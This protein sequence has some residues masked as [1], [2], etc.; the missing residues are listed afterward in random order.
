[1][2]DTFWARINQESA[3]NDA[4]NLEKDIAPVEITFV[5][6]GTDGDTFLDPGL[7]P[8]T[9][10]LINGTLYDFEYIVYGTLPNAQQVPD[11]FE[12]DAVAIIRVIGYPTATETERFVFLP[13]ANATESDMAS[14]QQGN[15]SPI[16]PDVLPQVPVC[17]AAGTLIETPRGPVLVDDLR[18][19]DLVMTVDDGP[20]P[21]IWATSSHHVWPGSDEKFKP[22]Q[23][24][25]GALG[26]GLPHCDL[27]VSPQHHIL[28]RTPH[29][30]DSFGQPEVI[31]PAKGLTGL[32]GVR[33]MKGKKD[34]TYFHLMLDRHALLWAGG[35]AS[36]SFYPGPTAIKMLNDAQRA[37]LFAL[38]PALQDNPETGYGPTVRHKITRRQAETLVSQISDSADTA[39]KAA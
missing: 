24:K 32:A 28:L 31:A 26:D 20:Q 19:G 3:G 34:V 21:L 23:I 33:H 9:Q 35:I 6:K 36:E 25:A 37:A 18:R 22:V 17:F 10:V 2:A 39:R 15:I 11:Q 38:F 12:G 1:M 5:A 13:E 29:C 27:I 8:N 30:A 4:I 16:Q 14:F 7:D